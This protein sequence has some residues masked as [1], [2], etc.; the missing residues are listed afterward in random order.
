MDV[1]KQGLEYHSNS[2]HHH[3]STKNARPSILRTTIPQNSK[4]KDHHSNSSRTTAIINQQESGNGTINS[5]SSNT[6]GEQLHTTNTTTDSS[7][8]TEWIPSISSFS[9]LLSALVREAEWTNDKDRRMELLS[10]V[11]QYYTK[12]VTTE[13]NVPSV[14]DKVI[15]DD[16]DDDKN[17]CDGMDRIDQTLLLEDR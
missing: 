14:P 3:H 1:W 15:H 2:N 16:D 4:D 6:I 12:I 9:A 10:L 7:G 13:D 17:D 5:S 8:T 11:V